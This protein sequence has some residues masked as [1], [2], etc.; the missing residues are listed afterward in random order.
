MPKVKKIR[1][2]VEYTYPIHLPDEDILD[3]FAKQIIEDATH[4]SSDDI[5]VIDGDEE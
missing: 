1:F 3:M 4:I 5:Q 2:E